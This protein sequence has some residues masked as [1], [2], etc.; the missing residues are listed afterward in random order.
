MRY[1][2]YAVGGIALAS[3][4][5]VLLVSGL[6]SIE[7]PFT[8]SA[9]C[10]SLVAALVAAGVLSRR[11]QLLPAVLIVA[12]AASFLFL[13]FGPW[14]VEHWTPGPTGGSVHRHT[15]WDLG[16]VH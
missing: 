1:W 8:R 12:F 11:G 16:H 5:L 9:F 15:L 3:E 2:P 7:L 13:S 14:Y 6:F 4:G 10:L